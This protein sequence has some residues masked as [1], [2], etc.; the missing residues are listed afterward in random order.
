MSEEFEIPITI[1]GETGANFPHPVGP[2]GHYY[3]F[4]GLPRVF[5]SKLTGV[6]DSAYDATG[7]VKVKDVE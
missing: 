6:V 1:S 3:W 5:E 2:G 4:L 7:S